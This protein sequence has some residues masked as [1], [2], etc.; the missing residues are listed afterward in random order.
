MEEYNIQNTYWTE[1]G[2]EQAFL[3]E[4]NTQKQVSYGFTDN[5]YLNC[6]LAMSKLYYDVYTNGGCNLRDCYRDY[7]PKY[8]ASFIRVAFSRLMDKAY[9]EQKMN[10]VLGFLKGKDL[11]CT[12]YPL[13]FLDSTDGDTETRKITLNDPNSG[14]WHEVV[15]GND[16]D[17][18]EWVNYVKNWRSVVVTV[19]D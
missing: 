3:R 19:V 10:A 5:A 11:S 4:L 8:I 18:T 12:I 15:F 13:W 16:A 6:Y 17:R 7:I 2:K 14:D 1:N 9:L